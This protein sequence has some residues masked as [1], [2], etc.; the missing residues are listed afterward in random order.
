MCFLFTEYKKMSL[1]KNKREGR[2]NLIFIHHVWTYHVATYHGI[3]EE[4]VWECCFYTLN[5]KDLSLG[6]NDMKRIN[7]IF[8]YHVWTYHEATYCET[9]EENA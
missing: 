1:T 8:A 6:K 3:G 5:T 9:G 2:I 4:K 7:L